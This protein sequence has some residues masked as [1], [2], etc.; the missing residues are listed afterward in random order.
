MVISRHCVHTSL[1]FIP[2]KPWTLQKPSRPSLTVQRSSS[3]SGRLL[4]RNAT[5]S[6]LL[7]LVEK[8]KTSPES[9]ITVLQ[10][11]MKTWRWRGNEINYLITG[12]GPAVFLVHGFG[13]SILH[14]RQT[15]PFLAQTHTVSC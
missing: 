11:K 14:F 15:I 7:D 3:R 4:K 13:G 10:E 9:S 8:E 12:E 5:S 1:G 2:A 6:V